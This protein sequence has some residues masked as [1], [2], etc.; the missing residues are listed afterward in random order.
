MTLDSAISTLNAALA[1][2][3]KVGGAV[4]GQTLTGKA[5]DLRVDWLPKA[6]E[7]REA[8]REVAIAANLY[9]YDEGFAEALTAIHRLLEEPK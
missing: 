4:I 6:A 2:P 7:I 8:V 9:A 3:P 5:I 1:E